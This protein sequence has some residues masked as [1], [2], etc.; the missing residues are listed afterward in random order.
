[1][2]KWLTSNQF[3]QKERADKEEQYMCRSIYPSRAGVAG[4]PLPSTSSAI[5]LVAETQSV[6]RFLFGIHSTLARGTRNV[7]TGK[8]SE[9]YS[10]SSQGNPQETQSPT[11][12]LEVKSIES[13][14]SRLCYVFC[15][16]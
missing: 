7:L 12:R 10:G 4:R 2:I 6:N 14:I 11:N 1:M 16:L 8:L 9:K 13:K 5:S 3:P 15:F